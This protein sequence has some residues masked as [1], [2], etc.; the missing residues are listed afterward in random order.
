MSIS[1]SRKKMRTILVVDDHPHVRIGVKYQI[2]QSGLSDQIFEAENG[3]DALRKLQEHKIDVVF[4]D[5]KMPG[6]DGYDAAAQILQRHPGTRVIMLS[7]F[8]DESLIV[9]LIRLGIHGYILKND[10]DIQRALEV[11]LAGEFYISPALQPVREKSDAGTAVLKPVKMTQKEERLLPLLA[12]GMNS[13]EIAEALSLTKNT[14]ES[15]R[16]EL[17]A[18]FE[19]SNCTELIDYAHR[20]GRL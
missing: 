20:T 10:P 6:M 17:L 12:K 16:K 19:V 11:V 1:E 13:R 14:V 3:D 8:D 15:Y 9:N 7:L 4:L 2:L 18:K 5:V